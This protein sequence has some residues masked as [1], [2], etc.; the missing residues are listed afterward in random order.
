L[1]LVVNVDLKDTPSSNSKRSPKL[2]ADPTLLR[3]ISSER[4]PHVDPME[5]ADE[6][7]DVDASAVNFE[8][9]GSDQRKLP[10]VLMYL[11]IVGSIPRLKSPEAGRRV[12]GCER[13]I[14]DSKRT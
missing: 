13:K 2:A 9:I 8:L 14:I 3:T 5:D 6:D 1:L 7:L 10:F 11:P 12:G 4:L